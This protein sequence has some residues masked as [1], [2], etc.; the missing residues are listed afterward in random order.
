MALWNT[1]DTEKR[2]ILEETLRE[3]PLSHFQWFEQLLWYLEV[4]RGKPVHTFVFRYI[5][6]TSSPGRFKACLQILTT[7]GRN[8]TEHSDEMDHR[9]TDNSKRV[10]WLSRELKTVLGGPNVDDKKVG[11]ACVTSSNE[12][13]K[14]VELQ[15]AIQGL[16]LD[17]NLL[18]RDSMHE[19]IFGPRKK[20]VFPL[21]EPSYLQHFRALDRQLYN[22]YHY[23]FYSQ[24]MW[25]IEEGHG[26]PIFKYAKDTMPYQLSQI[27]NLKLKWTRRDCNWE[28]LDVGKFI[29]LYT[30]EGDADGM[31]N[32]RACYDFLRISEMATHELKRTWSKKLDEVSMMPLDSLIIDARD[33]FAPHGDYLGLIT[34]HNCKWSRYSILPKNLQVLAPDS[35]LAGQIYDIIVAKKL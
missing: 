2:A 19:D 35:D 29:N 30:K 23:I 8:P 13:V 32:M 5:F 22:K 20:I 27:R 1:L 9:H 3:A 24:N 18:I 25:V 12:S 33:A 17:V 26:D 14:W 16:P 21:R 7:P 6:R 31:D 11:L 28:E 10:E 34:A 4:H 15:R